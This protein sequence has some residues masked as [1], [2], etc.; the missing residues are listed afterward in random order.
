MNPRPPPFTPFPPRRALKVNYFP[1]KDGVPILDA[2]EHNT[3]SKACTLDGL[4]ELF[5]PGET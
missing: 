1:V 5:E 2:K 4:P 3:L